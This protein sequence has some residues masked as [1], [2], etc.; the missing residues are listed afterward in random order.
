MD[1]IFI[2]K[3]ITLI[4]YKSGHKICRFISV[5]NNTLPFFFFFFPLR[6]FYDT[7]KIRKL[8]KKYNHGVGGHEETNEKKKYQY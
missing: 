4:T 8:K 1:I 3:E 2:Y 7:I 5:P 6:A